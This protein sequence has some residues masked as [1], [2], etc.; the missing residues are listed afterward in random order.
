MAWTRQAG[1][2]A[3]TRAPSGGTIEG[4]FP[5]VGGELDLEHADLR[6]RRLADRTAQGVGQELMAEAE[7][8]ERQAAVPDGLV[9]RRLLGHEPGILFFFPNVHR[10]AHDPEPV[11]GAQVRDR[12][13]LVELHGVPFDSVRG[14]E[15]AED[16]GML[17]VDMLE[18]QEAGCLGHGSF[19]F[20]GTRIGRKIARF[21]ASPKTFCCFSPGV[22][23]H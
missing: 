5:A 21:P 14:K 17:E 3:S 1:E 22:I 23:A 2:A 6:R 19:S 10:P 18:D 4:A 8:E 9:D 16:A 15:V 7:P 12:L 11:V 20:V 13:A